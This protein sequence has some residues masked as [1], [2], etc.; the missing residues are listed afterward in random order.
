MTIEDI[1]PFMNSSN[2][3]LKQFQEEVSDWIC[4]HGDEGINPL[5]TTALW[6]AEEFDNNN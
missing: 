1:K 6:L 3:D 4:E 5:L 2:F